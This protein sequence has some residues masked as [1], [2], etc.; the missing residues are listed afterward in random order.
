MCDD[1]EHQV[2]EHDATPPKGSRR[3][4]FGAASGGILAGAG[5]GVAG[6]IAVE[7]NW[8]SAPQ[9]FVYAGTTGTDRRGIVPIIWSVPVSTNSFSLTF[10]DGPDP[11]FTP[12]VLE[13]LARFGVPATFNVMGWNA[14]HHGDL[15][16]EVIA[17]GH[18]IANHS[19]SHLDAADTETD[20]LEREV[21][22]GK[23]IIEEVSGQTLTFFRPP[24]GNITGA[25]LRFAAAAHEQVLVWSFNGGMPGTPTV[26]E[27][28]DRSIASIGPGDIVL[29]HDGIGRGTFQRD[30]S[31]ARDLI[32]ARN[33]EIEAL[34]GVIDG[35]LARGLRPM[36]V[37]QLLAEPRVGQIGT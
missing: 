3:A 20:V 34:P 26:A 5:L 10:D 18:E 25:Q 11:E 7:S 2:N 24:R 6:T 4:L 22:Y 16:K 32:A 33:R 31:S 28:R 27:L 15:L 8:P 21:A 37:S 9:D 13:A 14:L 29:L 23:Q 35:V 1:P 17:A 19:W 36:T 12:R 30:T